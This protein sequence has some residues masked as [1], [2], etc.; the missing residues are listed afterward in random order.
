[1]KI[2]FTIILIINTLVVFAQSENEIKIQTNDGN[3]YIGIIIEEDEKMVKMLIG[4]RDIVQLQQANILTKE[5]F[6]RR[7]KRHL[8]SFEG[9]N[10]ITGLNYDF[11]FYKKDNLSLGGT[12]GIGAWGFKTGIYAGFRQPWQDI[13]KVEVGFGQTDERRNNFSGTYLELAYRSQRNNRW[14]FWEVN[15][16]FLINIFDER[17]RVFGLPYGGVA[18]GVYF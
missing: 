3:I 13:F 18:V 15:S 7:E 16:G 14:Y 1:M 12:A 11:D 6:I 17:N 10:F 2:I 5:S 9:S 8:I 4:G